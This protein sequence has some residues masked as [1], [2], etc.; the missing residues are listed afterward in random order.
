MQKQ[1]LQ[2]EFVKY[3]KSKLFIVL[4]VVIS[5]SINLWAEDKI[6]QQVE[7]YWKQV[8]KRA[9]ELY[10]GLN[11]DVKINAGVERRLDTTGKYNQYSD[12]SLCVPLYS[13]K[14]KQDINEKKQAF[15]KEYAELIG[16]YEQDERLV[17]VLREKAKVMKV[18]IKDAGIK[19]ASSYFE[20]VTAI[21]E[22]ESEIREL[23]RKLGAVVNP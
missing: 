3:S 8:K 6:D 21:V 18:L 15:L 13:Q 23:K 20:V 12:F 17:P 4:V 5:F 16:K 11:M 7:I 14:D 19:E 22:R 9:D 10:G 1:K 2:E